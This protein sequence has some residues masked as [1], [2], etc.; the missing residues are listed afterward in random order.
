MTVVVRIA[1]ED[2]LDALLDVQQ[3]GSVAGLGHI[4]PQ[5]RYPFPRSVV[6]ERWREE[7]ADPAIHVY[8]CVDETGALTGFAAIRGND[9]LHFGTALRTWGTGVAAQFHEALLDELAYTAP[10]GVDHFRLRVFEENLRARRFYEKL[11]WR[12]TALRTRSSFP[13]YAVLLEYR[14]PR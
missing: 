5:D 8:V 3:E 14:L 10:S 4:F 1:H 13:P 11:G 7:L 2:D 12:P 6:R 9:L